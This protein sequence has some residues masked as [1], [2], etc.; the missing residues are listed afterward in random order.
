MRKDAL[1]VQTFQP[2]SGSL[3]DASSPMLSLQRVQGTEAER[4]HH[5][6]AKNAKKVPAFS[7]LQIQYSG[8]ITLQPGMQRWIAWHFSTGFTLLTSSSA[9]GCK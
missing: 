1:L 8:H 4:K 2:T 9:S 7:H 6:A 5:P 3:S